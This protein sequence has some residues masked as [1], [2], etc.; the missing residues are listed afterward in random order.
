MEI[1]NG[2]KMFNVTEVCEKT[3]ISLRT[4]EKY[5][6]SG[7]MHGVKIRGHWLVSETSLNDFLDGKTWN[8]DKK[9]TDTFQADELK[10]FFDKAC[11]GKKELFETIIESYCLGFERGTGTLTD[12]EPTKQTDDVNVKVYR[13]IKGDNL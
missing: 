1:I 3:T 10:V 2:K 7:K 5:L 4:V 8:A 6:R 9:P 12:D 13:Q 11:Q